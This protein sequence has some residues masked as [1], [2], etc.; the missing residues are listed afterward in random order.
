MDIRLTE[1]SV[2]ERVLRVRL[3]RIPEESGVLRAYLL[4]PDAPDQPIGAATLYGRGAGSS[5][6]ERAM[7]SFRLLPDVPLSP[8]ALV[9]IRLEGVGG[10]HAVSFDVLEVE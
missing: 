10:E 1:A 3:R 8:G 5:A 4:G 9:E 2:R 6:R 7:L